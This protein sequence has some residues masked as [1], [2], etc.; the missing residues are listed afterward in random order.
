M[1]VEWINAGQV[2]AASD[3]RPAFHFSPAM[4]LLSL[5]RHWPR[6]GELAACVDGWRV[7]ANPASLAYDELVETAPL[8]RMRHVGDMRLLTEAEHWRSP[9]ITG[10]PYCV[11]PYDVIV[12]KV[13]RVG[14]A[15]VNELHRRHPVDANLA[16][17]RG[18]HP[19]QALW[20]TF[21][22]NQRLYR[23]YL[24]TTD[25]ITNLV[26]VGIKQLAS[27]PM[28]PMPV[29][30]LDLATAY[31][32]ELTDLDRA[33]E[34]LFRLRN[35]VND[36]LRERFFDYGEFL[37]PGMDRCRWH[38]CSAE[39]LTN[40][41]NIAVLE[42]HS[43]ARRL[44][45]ERLAVPLGDLAR[46]SPRHPR[47]AQESGCRVLRISDVDDHFGIADHLG[48]RDEMAW[49]TQRRPVAQYDVLISAFSAEGKVALITDSPAGCVLPT[50]Q[51]ITLCFH[52]HQGA[53]A[54]LLESVL[55]QTQWTRLAT[56]SL[57]RFVQPGLV[58][59]LVLPVL[60]PEQAQAWHERLVDILR[61]RQK[62][63]R[64]MAGMRTD[65]INLY[66][67]LHPVFDEETLDAEQETQE[68]QTR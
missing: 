9:L 63:Q 8:Y 58:H 67:R 65:M 45:Q 39:D 10:Q 47:V 66:R 6:L 21:C 62:A 30:F 38:W 15:L 59:Q 33:Q 52:R 11:Q 56:G 61:K 2:F 22:L 42:Q 54:L 19:A 1:Q 37:K 29:G 34:Q 68:W 46:I 24:E 50:E 25:T 16:I 13:G 12:R 44:R 23:S 26:R 27:I 48:G 51:L 55:V 31:L 3:W 64:S 36:W 20:V 43:L 32:K 5:G 28:A 57:Q 4:R 35:E 49:R 14:A 40:M 17:V 41:L 60:E 53:Y 18:L 7:S